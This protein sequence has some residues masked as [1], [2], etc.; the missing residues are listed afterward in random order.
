MSHNIA[1]E[2]ASLWKLY[3]IQ[4]TG[5][6]PL[7][8]TPAA[9]QGIAQTPEDAAVSDGRAFW[10]LRDINLTINRGEAVGLIGRNGAGKSTLLKVLSR[11]TAPTRG[12][13]RIW[14]SIASLLEVGTG[15]HDELTGRENI[16]LNA[17]I[18]G[19]GAKEINRQFD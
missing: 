12:H 19:M 11:I 5:H 18:L 6:S 16:A 8:A 9:Q 17:T 10:A 15:F 13:V 14:G 3:W 2:I 7:T 4:R 1:V